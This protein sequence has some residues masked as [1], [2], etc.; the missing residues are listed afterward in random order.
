MNSRTLLILSVAAV[1]AIWQLPYGRQALYPLTLLATFAHFQANAA[2]LVGA[3]SHLPDA[4]SVAVVSV[5]ICFV[6]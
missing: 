6:L 4:G 2:E 1:A 3:L 5:V